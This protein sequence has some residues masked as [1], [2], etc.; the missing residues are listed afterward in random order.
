LRSSQEI[1][2]KNGSRLADF[3]SLDLRADYKI[4]SKN[5]SW[6][7]FFD[8]VDIQ[9]RFNQ[10]SAIFQP[11]TGRTYFLGLAI[12]PTFGLRVEL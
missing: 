8:I 11:L 2:D 6:T 9:N 7:A 12:F 4:K 1:T 3:I 5:N 10:S